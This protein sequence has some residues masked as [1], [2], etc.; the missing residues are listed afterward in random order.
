MKRSRAKSI[1]KSRKKRQ[2]ALSKKAKEKGSI[3]RKRRVSR[4]ISVPGVSS[5]RKSK[6]T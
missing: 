1:A 4:L 6:E 5:K 2:E 3:I